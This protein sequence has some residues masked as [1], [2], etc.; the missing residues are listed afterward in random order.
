VAQTRRRCY[1]G[2]G[3][4]AEPSHSKEEWLGV[5]DVLPHLNDS[6][7]VLKLEALG[8]NANRNADRP[9]DLPSKTICGSGNQVGARIFDHSEP[10][11]LNV[12]TDG[13]GSSNN[14][15]ANSV[16][17]DITKPSKTIHNNRP[18]LR[19]DEPQKIRSL[20]L[21]ETLILQGFNPDY[22][23]DS[24]KTQK[25]RWTMVGNAVPPPVAAA[26]IRGVQNAVFN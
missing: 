20:T 10:R 12:N 2:E 15:R 17:S 26:V 7:R 22:K 14:R 4:V 23:L 19:T 13:C 21:P 11:V 8:A 3:W 5:I 6:L 18:S 16:D 24:A 9:I 25:N 1:A